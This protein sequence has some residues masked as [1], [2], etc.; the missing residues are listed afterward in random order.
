MLTHVTEIRLKEENFRLQGKT[1]SIDKDSNGDI[2][3]IAA[4]IAASTTSNGESNSSVS[5]GLLNNNNG[6][7]LPAPNPQTTPKRLHV[8]NIP[9]RFRDPDLRNMFGVSIH[10]IL[11][12][13]FYMYYIR[14]CCRETHSKESFCYVLLPLFKDKISFLPS[15]LVVLGAKYKNYDQ[16]L[17]SFQVPSFLRN[18]KNEFRLSF[19]DCA[20]CGYIFK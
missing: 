9:F 5:G 13:L 7:L 11:L 18:F 17:L 8:S 14:I 6:A 2:T 3:T 4:S 15:F 12:Y 10:P 1:E 16:F 20:L 19:M